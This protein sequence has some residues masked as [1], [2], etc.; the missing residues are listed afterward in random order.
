VALGLLV[1]GEAAVAI[2]AAMKSSP[3]TPPL[4]PGGGAPEPLNALARG[5]G[6]TGL[7]PES[8]AI[9]G[10]SVMV[11][12]SAGFLLALREAW[13]G[14][15]SGR[16][17][18]SLAVAFQVLAIVLPLLTS[19]RDAYSY[20]M[21][22][23]IAVAYHANPYV[24]TPVDFP[25]D[26]LVPF[27][28]SV[29]RDT[30]SVYGPVF[31]LLCAAVAWLISSPLG[32]VLAFKLLAGLAVIGTVVLIAWL[33]RRV[34]PGRVSFAVA[35]FG[36]NP[37]IV[38][39]VTGAGHNDA[40]VG[41]CVAASLA[42]LVRAGPHI[43]RF[44]PALKGGEGR[45]WPELAAVTL[46]T[47]GTLVKVSAAPA[48]VLVIV[49]SIAA[50]DPGRRIRLLA[51]EAGIVF[52]IT[53]ILTGPYWQTANPTFG[54][55]TVAGNLDWLSP[56]HLL[57]ATGGR[58]A[59]HLWGDPGRLLAEAGIRGGLALVAAAGLSWT[60]IAVVRRVIRTRSEVSDVKQTQDAS[61]GPWSPAAQGAAWAWGLLVVILASPVIQPWYLAW[62]LPVAWLLP[63]KALTLTI[64]LSVVLAVS[65]SVFEPESVPS[66]WHWFSLTG[67]YVI[68]PA[69]LVVLG[70]VVLQTRRIASGSASL[71]S[72]DLI[73]ADDSWR[74]AGVE[75]SGV[76]NRAS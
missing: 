58:M 36:W 31:V 43:A 69:L 40:L 75:D 10:V 16:M 50:R 67:S 56:A 15:I 6:L 72:G 44:F 13:R 70:W 27:V 11:A 41:L 37:A 23:R 48:L 76:H 51:V 1:A 52:G 7:S 74:D 25:Q 3:Y 33:A 63:R 32:L 35:A 61:G 4:L 18:V 17:A 55:S 73:Q 57:F 68:G 2:V 8:A 14:T 42:F 20:A 60:A 9:L 38:F 65:Y 30:P 66:V 45:L 24:A 71:E 53:V 5:L 26:S 19:G 21:I 29:W 28:A 12:A 64:A 34:S 59:V 62:L 39:Y 49:A 22:G 47:L 54:L 46:L